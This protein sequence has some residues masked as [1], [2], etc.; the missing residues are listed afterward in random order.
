MR[1]GCCGQRAHTPIY[2]YV[3]WGPATQRHASTAIKAG[4]IFFGDGE[5][6]P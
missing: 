4:C 2:L 3:C 5:V 1:G 6:R